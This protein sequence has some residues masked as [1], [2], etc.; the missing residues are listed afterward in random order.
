M[1]EFPA[2]LPAATRISAQAGPR[3]WDRGYASLRSNAWGALF[4]RGEACLLEEEPQE[5]QVLISSLLQKALTVLKTGVSPPLAAFGQ[6]RSSDYTSVAIVRVAMRGRCEVTDGNPDEAM[7]LAAKLLELAVEVQAGSQAAEAGL[8]ALVFDDPSLRLRL[9]RR[10]SRILPSHLDYEDVAASVFSKVVSAIKQKKLP[11]VADDV[12]PWLIRV[13]INAAIDLRRLRRNTEIAPLPDDDKAQAV[14][15][16]WPSGKASAAEIR[17][18][19]R[20]LESCLDNLPSRQQEAMLLLM[21]EAKY[22]EIAEEL[23]IAIGTVGVTLSKARAK[24]GSCMDE[25]GFALAGGV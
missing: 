19:L 5:G 18:A 21:T 7:K 14:I 9:V 12:I 2:F 17:Q 4:S 22:K 13:F 20:Q 11:N 23:G 16:S 10:M 8:L 25:N 6:N 15:A 24:L 3:V 1:S